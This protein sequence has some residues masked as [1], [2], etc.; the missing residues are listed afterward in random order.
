[1]PVQTHDHYAWTAYTTWQTS[2]D[3]LIQ[4]AAM[5][6]QYCSFLHHNGISDYASKYTFASDGPSEEDLQEP[7]EFLSRFL[8]PS[9][10]WDSL[11]FSNITNEVQ[12]YSLI[13]LD[14]EKKLFSIH[15]LV[16]AWSRTTVSNPEKYMSTTG[17]I[18]GMALSKHPQHDIQLRSLAICPHVELAV[19]MDAQVALVFKGNMN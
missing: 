8:G 1:M 17:S 2:V 10:E 12:A 4:P 16:Y 13:S 7:L 19:Q 9:G 3:R 11:Q 14:T 18:L 15:P 5:F 6:L